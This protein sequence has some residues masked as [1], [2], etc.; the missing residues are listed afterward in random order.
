MMQ[1]QRREE[2]TQIAQGQIAP[3]PSEPPPEADEH[4]GGVGGVLREMSG[5]IPRTYINAVVKVL[6]SY[7]VRG[8]PVPADLVEHVS[9]LARELMSMPSPRMRIAGAKIVA[10]ALKHNLALIEVADRMAR[11]DSG[12]ATENV[13]HEHSVRYIRG[14]SEGEL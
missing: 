10:A 11:L 2:S 13:R 8:I 7:S 14:V 1:E 9:A 6:E 3:V 12:A 5:Y 4:A